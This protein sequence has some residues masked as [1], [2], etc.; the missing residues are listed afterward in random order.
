MLDHAL[1]EIKAK[2]REIGIL[3]ALSQSAKMFFWDV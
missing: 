2:L 1:D 3:V